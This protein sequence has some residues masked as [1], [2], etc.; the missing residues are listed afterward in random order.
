MSM[1]HEHAER[2]VKKEEEE[3]EEKKEKLTAAYECFH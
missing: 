2:V 1:G 3:E